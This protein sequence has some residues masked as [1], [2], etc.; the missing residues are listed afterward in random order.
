MPAGYKLRPLTVADEDA[1]YRFLSASPCDNV[2]MM[3]TLRDW[4]FSNPQVRQF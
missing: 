1:V 4:G 3:A 2:M